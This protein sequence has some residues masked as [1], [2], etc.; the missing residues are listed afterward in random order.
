MA[1]KKKAKHTVLYGSAGNKLYAKR[2]ANGQ[3]NDIQSYQRDHA[4]DLRRNAKA[5][6]PRMSS[7]PSPL[8]RWL[9]LSGRA[10]RCPARA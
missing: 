7:P 3:F 8:P 5:E 2:D 9:P 4:A 1:S 6:A 10:I